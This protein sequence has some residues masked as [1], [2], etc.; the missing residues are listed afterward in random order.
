MLKNPNPSHSW[1]Q[2]LSQNHTVQSTTEKLNFADAYPLIAG[3][4]DQPSVEIEKYL[5]R[6][7]GHTPWQLFY[8]DTISFFFSLCYRDDSQAF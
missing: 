7:P 3:A 5:S 1:S 4:F 6:L 8:F 2:S